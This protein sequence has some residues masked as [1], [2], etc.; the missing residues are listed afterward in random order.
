MFST[1]T[2]GP[3]RV[4]TLSKFPDL[5]L[6]PS[7]THLLD[8]S[9]GLVETVLSIHQSS[10]LSIATPDFQEIL[11]VHEIAIRLMDP[12]SRMLGHEER[13]VQTPPCLFPL[14]GCQVELGEGQE[15]L[16]LMGNLANLMELFGRLL[17][18]TPCIVK[19]PRPLLEFPG[20]G[21]L[22]PERASRRP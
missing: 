15:H 16:R 21:T 3:A 17:Q 20:A 19:S 8:Q 13:L 1:R 18:C 2:S 9:T 10:R 22:D 7:I 12:Q 11:S 5:L 6:S 4:D 14:L